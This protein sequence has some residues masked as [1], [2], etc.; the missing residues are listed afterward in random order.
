MFFFPSRLRIYV[1][2]TFLI[3]NFHNPGFAAL[4]LFNFFVPL[5]HLSFRC[6]LLLNCF[7]FFSDTFWLILFEFLCLEA[8]CCFVV[9]WKPLKGTNELSNCKKGV[10][11]K[12]SERAC[13][14]ELWKSLFFLLVD[15]WLN[16]FEKESVREVDW[17]RKYFF[18]VEKN[19]I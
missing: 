15:S 4:K 11:R 3:Y 16:N 12:E 17:K 2:W 1:L 6:K 7:P 10:R 18:D 19:S 9:R 5:L 14:K 13:L 8:L